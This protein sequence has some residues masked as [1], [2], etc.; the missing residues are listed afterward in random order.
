MSPLRIFAYVTRHLYLYKRSLP[1]LM[2]VF[3]WP[4]LDLMVWGF[5]TV[6]LGSYKAT[7]PAFI[8]FFIGALI[9]WDILFR[10]QQS[11]SVSF[12]EDMW[13]RNL[14]NIFVS[15]L[16]PLEYVASLL[17]I[18]MIKLLLASS[19]MVVIAYL[20]YSFNVFTLGFH[21]VPLVIN[22]LIMGW[23]MGVITTGVILRFGQEAEVLAW[24]V[25]FL[26]Q[27]LSAVFYPVEVLPP[28]LQKIA[29]YIPSAHVFEGMRH[30][31][32]EKTLP[33]DHLIMAIVLNIVY[34]AGSALFFYWNFQSVKKKGL[35][36]KVGE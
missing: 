31:I 32:N 6:Y 14:L 17:I 3:Y 1:R 4:I 28:I 19:V 25:A 8:T 15:P 30:V 35:L 16:T 36:V 27:P 33:T 21:L 26:F 12:L 24:G 7:L 13:S 11:I 23:A 2:E 20:L 22:L 5:I 34:V 9:L 18:S 29:Y 10:S